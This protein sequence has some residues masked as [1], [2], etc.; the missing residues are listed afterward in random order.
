MAV[1]V[2]FQ[3]E[4]FKWIISEVLMLKPENVNIS[5]VQTENWLKPNQLPIQSL[6]YFVNNLVIQL[7]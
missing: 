7:N 4:D 5:F 6:H 2:T 3:T 1:S